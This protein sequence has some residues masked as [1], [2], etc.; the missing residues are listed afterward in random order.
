M[1]LIVVLVIISILLV[2]TIPE[3]TQKIFRDDKEITLNWIVLNVSQLKKQAR[4]Q[5]KNL[6]MC[7]NPDKN[8]ISIRETQKSAD[9][10]D[11]NT[12]AEFLLPDNVTLEGVEFNMPGQ[13]ALA[14]T[15]IQFYKKGYSDH[16]IIHISDNEGASF[17]CLIQPFL[18][19]VKVY[20]DYIQFQ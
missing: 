19:R 15:C 9:S 2:F 16:A 20:E 13:K 14:D 12:L 17:S 7:V 1:E 11:N 18:H 6:F 4:N 3:F 10:D 5:G 8:T